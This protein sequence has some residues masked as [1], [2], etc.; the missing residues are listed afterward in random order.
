MSSRRVR[1]SGGQSARKSARQILLL[2][3]PNILKGIFL[4]L[5]L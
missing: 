3:Q 5:I 1:G 4:T 2:I